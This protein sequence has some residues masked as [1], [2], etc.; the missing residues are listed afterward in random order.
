MISLQNLTKRYGDQTAVDDLT[1]EVQA[2]RVTGF[3]G[4]NGAG[5]STTMRMITGLDRPDSGAALVN[6]RPYASLAAPLRVVGA[7][8]DARAAHPGRTAVA[9]LRGMARSNGIPTS[10]AAAVLERV[11]LADVQGKRVGEFSLGMGQRLA[12]AA[13]LLGDPAVLLL[14]EPVN[15]L[16][17]DGVRWIRQLMRGLADEGRTVL[18]SSHLMS[19]MEDTADH[20]IV[21]G[22]GKLIIDAPMQEVIATSTS[23]AIRVRS[24]EAAVLRRHLDQAGMRVTDADDALLVTGGSLDEI[25][26]LAFRNGVRIYELASRLATLEDAYMELTA[27]SV[28][29][30]TSNAAQQSSTP[31]TQS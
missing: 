1:L 2:G 13:A 25:G 30:G 23:N 21:I 12:I 5:K 14:D 9:H 26:E 4:P 28:V 31:A 10:R 3:L 27:S 16:D 6:G 15:G 17:P 29:Y 22:R 18:V 11:G 24:P 20:L 19:E 8:L 7:A